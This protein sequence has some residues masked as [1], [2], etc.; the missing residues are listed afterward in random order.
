MRRSW[1]STTRPF[2]T[3]TATTT[4]EHQPI[5]VR[6]I[7]P[8]ICHPRP[9]M[10]DRSCIPVSRITYFIRPAPAFPT[11][12][13]P[14]YRAAL[15]HPAV[16]RSGILQSSCNQTISIGVDFHSVVFECLTVGRRAA[17]DVED[18]AAGEPGVD[19]KEAVLES[20]MDGVRSNP[21]RAVLCREATASVLQAGIFVTLEPVLRRSGL[22]VPPHSRSMS[23]CQ[24]GTR[25]HQ[26]TG[27]LFESGA[28]LEKSQHCKR[29]PHPFRHLG[30]GGPGS[31]IERPADRRTTAQSAP[32]AAQDRRGEAPEAP[33]VL[34]ATTSVGPFASKVD[35]CKLHRIGYLQGHPAHAVGAGRA[36]SAPGARPA[37]RSGGPSAARAVRGWGRA[38]GPGAGRARDGILSPQSTESVT[39]RPT[40][41]NCLRRHQRTQSRANTAQPLTSHAPHSTR[42]PR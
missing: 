12:R 22:A 27:G 9:T 30:G 3:T 19:S 6:R 32:A 13:L 5:A 39:H 10:S 8:H 24:R 21:S 36:P 25:R 16:E 15:L 33:A 1:P 35:G 42:Q 11:C 18:R 31:Q 28:G 41:P 34:T 26:T 17:D 29:K 20:R 23:V 40:H 7:A 2:R 4:S 37:D 14:T 38:R